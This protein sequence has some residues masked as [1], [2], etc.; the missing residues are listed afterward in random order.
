MD[1]S[2]DDRLRDKGWSI[3]GQDKIRVR[4]RKEIAQLDGVLR[5]KDAKIIFVPLVR[6]NRRGP[7]LLRGGRRCLRYSRRV[8]C[9]GSGDAGI[10]LLVN[11]WLRWRGLLELRV[12]L[13]VCRY[14]RVGRR[15]VSLTEVRRVY[16]ARGRCI[17]WSRRRALGR[18]RLG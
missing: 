13:D 2:Q 17:I 5:V 12:V 11:R 18:L 14:G 1:K 6:L 8:R 9:L 15:N 16:V 4:A 7:F 10:P 3:Q